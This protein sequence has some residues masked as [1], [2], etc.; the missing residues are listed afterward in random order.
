VVENRGQCKLRLSEVAGALQSSLHASA[1]GFMLS[2][3]EEN[4]LGYWEKNRIQKKR[5]LRQFSI[6]LP[7]G[8][9]MVVVLFLNL[10]SGWYKKADMVLRGNSSVIVVIV[11]A[12]VGI[13]FFITFFAGS[14]KWDQNEQ[15][16]QELLIKKQRP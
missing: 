11:I 2:I 4:F 5:F 10:L 7:I 14:H 8:V 12:V 3:E 15:R 16:Y 9:V 13:V 1:F 6:G